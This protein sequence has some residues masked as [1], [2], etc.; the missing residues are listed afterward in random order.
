MRSDSDSS[1]NADRLGWPLADGHSDAYADGLCLPWRPGPGGDSQSLAGWQ[2]HTMGTAAAG[3]VCAARACWRCVC[4]DGERRAR[5][6]RATEPGTGRVARGAV[7]FLV[8]LCGRLE[9]FVGRLG[10]A[11]SALASSAET[12]RTEPISHATPRRDHERE[13]GRGLP[14]SWLAGVP[15]HVTRSTQLLVVRLE[16]TIGRGRGAGSPGR[17]RRYRAVVLALCAAGVNV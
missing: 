7:F 13:R 4:G 1:A 2:L 16:A 5:R 12:G 3:I 17:G 8:A 6:A 14:G 9:P 11:V 10:P 15:W